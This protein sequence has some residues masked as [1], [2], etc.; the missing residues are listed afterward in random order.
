MVDIKRFIKKMELE[1]YV[2]ETLIEI[3]QLVDKKVKKDMPGAKIAVR[4]EL[5]ITENPTLRRVDDERKK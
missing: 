3:V 4:I 5:G 2:M 1:G